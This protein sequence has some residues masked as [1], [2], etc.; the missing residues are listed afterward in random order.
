MTTTTAPATP[1]L[2]TEVVTHTP[3]RDISLPG[4]AGTMAL[5]T[6]DNG[7][8]HT[9]PNTF[10]PEG[11]AGLRSAVDTLRTRAAAGEIQAVG[12]TGKPFIFAVGADLSGV[13]YVTEREQATGIARSGHGAFAAIM[14]LP[15]PTFAFVNG[16]AMGG[17]VE[18]ALACDHRTISAGVPAFALPE[19]FLGL[20]PGWGGCYLLPNLVGVQNALK[21][22]IDNP[23]SQNR[24]LKAKEVM[25]LGIADTMLEPAD[26]LEDSLRWAAGVVSGE[27]TVQRPEVD[28][29]EQAWEAT[30]DAARKGVLAK[31]GGRSPGRCAPSSSSGLPAPPTVR[32]PS[33]PRTRRSA[34]SS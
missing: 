26:F 5:I 12:I 8:D 25:A 30:C 10:G 1:Q 11:I 9:R 7:L 31:T 2:P 18:I 19:T 20:V 14:D 28:R 24:M 4:G 13:P 34:T 32:A 3:V 16:A 29:D 15:V 21:V 33:P 23:L 27:V 17:G 6:L 22:I